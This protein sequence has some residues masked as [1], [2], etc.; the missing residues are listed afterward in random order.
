MHKVERESTTCVSV[1]SWFLSESSPSA[2]EQVDEQDDDGYDQQQ[3]DETS[4]HVKAK[5]QKPQN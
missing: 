4:G 1:I 3:M 2:S 5:S